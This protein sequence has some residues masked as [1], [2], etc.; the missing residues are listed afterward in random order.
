[1]ESCDY[2]LHVASPF[3]QV[4]DENTI[5]TAL[6]GTLNVLKACAKCH[7]VKKVVLTSSIAAIMCKFV[8]PRLA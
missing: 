7:S 3:P 8:L 1:M 5:R 6:D 2:V 4:G